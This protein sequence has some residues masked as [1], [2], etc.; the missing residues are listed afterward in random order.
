MRRHDF[1]ELPGG[2]VL[3]IAPHADDEVLG[4]PPEMLD[5]NP[6]KAASVWNQYRRELIHTLHRAFKAGVDWS[7][8]LRA[9]SL[10]Y[11]DPDIGHPR[12]DQYIIQEVPVTSF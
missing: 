9:L 5:A 1:K 3:V 11:G 2:H 10:V 4:V 6:D 8:A 12:I 7:Q